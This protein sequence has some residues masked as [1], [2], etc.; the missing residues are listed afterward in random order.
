MDRSALTQ[1]AVN[2]EIGMGLW[3]ASLWRGALTPGIL[4]FLA[5]LPV[6]TAIRAPHAGRTGD[7]HARL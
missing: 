5:M 2:V 7:A 6:M 3:A 1:I 4:L